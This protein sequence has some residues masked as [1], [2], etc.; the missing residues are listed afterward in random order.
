MFFRRKHP[1]LEQA[2]LQPALRPEL[3]PLALIRLSPGQ[4]TPANEPHEHDVRV[5]IV[6][7]T[8]PSPAR[9]LNRLPNIRAPCLT[10]RAELQP[11]EHHPPLLRQ[12]RRRVARH[13]LLLPF[14]LV[15]HRTPLTAGT[16][17]GPRD[18]RR[19][20]RDRHPGRHTPSHT[21]A[22]DRALQ[23]RRRARPHRRRR[24]RRLRAL[25]WG[26]RVL[27]CGRR[28]ERACARELRGQQCALRALHD[29]VFV[30]PHAHS[31][32]AAF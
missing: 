21:Y 22:P 14:L 23:E 5:L 9:T 8:H 1:L 3:R 29:V 4:T 24:G 19:R 27:W 15:R 18:G 11:R 6:M 16:R 2:P 28:R 13:G 10:Q 12:V 17:T 32:G 25:E 20:R 30:L 26:R 31:Q 7:R